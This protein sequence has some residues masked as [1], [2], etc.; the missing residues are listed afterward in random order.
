RRRNAESGT[1]VSATMAT[2]A[3]SQPPGTTGATTAV[4]TSQQATITVMTRPNTDPPRESG[5]RC[6]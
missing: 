2:A 3:V 1:A 5:R 6:L 4:T